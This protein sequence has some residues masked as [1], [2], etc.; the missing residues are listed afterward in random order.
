MKVSASEH[1]QY[2]TDAIAES[3][4]FNAK[5]FAKIDA[6]PTLT[7][8]QYQAMRGVIDRKQVNIDLLKT[9]LRTQYNHNV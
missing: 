2:L 9:I 4:A 6:T 5:L 1:I 8:K 3:E 7:D